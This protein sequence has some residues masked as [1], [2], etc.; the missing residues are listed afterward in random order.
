M[1]SGV[2]KGDTNEKLV[3]ITLAVIQTDLRIVSSRMQAIET[4]ARMRFGMF[5]PQPTERRRRWDGRPGAVMRDKADRMTPQ[6]AATLVR[7]VATRHDR[8]AFKELFQFY[9]PRIQTM[10][11][12]GGATS[13]AA[14]DLAQETLV[15]IWHKAASYDAE[16]TTVSAW[17]FTIA[18]NLR[19][20]RFRKDQRSRLH[21]VYELLQPTESLQPDEP[22]EAVERERLVRT[23]LD[24]LPEEQVRVVE[25]S[26]FEGQAHGD[27]ARTLG[28]PL[29]T[30][31]SRLRL[32]LARLREFL[33]DD[34]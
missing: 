3:W 31:K 10:L 15:A 20:D 23:A 5:S 32:A 4:A 27:I 8:E 13:E 21:H 19:V 18:R 12:R 9:A 22:L 33:G 25:L 29:G 30:V 34:R 26:F 11:M 2:S 16:R 28:I 6:I 17:I 7:A 1:Q 24:G 14:E